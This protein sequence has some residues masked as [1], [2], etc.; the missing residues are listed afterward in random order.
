MNS[1]NHIQTLK[2]LALAVLATPFSA[3]AQDAF[4]TLAPLTVTGGEEKVYELLGAAAYL[5]AEDIRASGRTDIGGLLAKIPGVYVRDEDG[6]GNFPNISLRGADG[7]RSE[8]V[9]I[10][11]DGILT[12]PSPYSAPAAYYSP[13]GARMSGIEVLKGSSQVRYG[14]QTTGGV[15]NFLSTEIP[16]ER[17]FYS[18][19]TYGSFNTFFNHT[20]YGDTVETEAGRIGYLLEL[21]TQT[22]DGFRDI[23]FS[24]RDTG[25]GLIEP[26]LKVFWEPD[27]ALK[28]RIEM[29]AGYTNFDSNETY[30]GLTETDLAANPDRRYAATQFDAFGSEQWRTYVKWIAEPSDSLRIE[31]AVYYNQFSRD[32]DKIDQVNGNPLHQALLTPAGVGTLNGSAAGNIRL[33]NNLRDHE[34]YGWQSQMNYLFETGQL[35]HDLGF[36]V[37]FH[38]DR[39]DA[40]RQRTVYNGNGTGGFALAP[41][42][43]GAITPN[44]TNET[45]ATAVFV[46]DEIKT[47]KFT[48]RPGIRY[49][50]LD[51]DFTNPAGGQF[52]GNENLFAAGVGGSYE[53]DENSS[54]F[55]GIYRGVASPSPQAYL[56]AGTENEE[57]LSYELGYRYRKDAFNA[58]VVGFFTDF[59]QLISTDAGFGFTNTNQNAGQAEVF[60]LET[61]VEYD[62]GND[63]NLGV[64]LPLYVS[65]TWT[66][67]QF[68]G[69]NIA[70][71]GG[72]GVYDGGRSGNEIPY[73]PDW[74][75]AAG[76][77]VTG[78]K[79]GVNLDMIY[80]SSMWGTGFNGDVRPGTQ[81][82]RD[83]EIPA[84]LLFDL[85]ANYRIN[86][87][88]KLVGGI[89]N[90][91]DERE[92][93]SRIPEGPRSNAPRVFFAGVEA[94]F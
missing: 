39:Q 61:L 55:G 84:L 52:S 29:K 15:I 43:P 70:G 33:S 37:R 82:I 27:T 9:T 16:D 24:G 45:F 50:W 31:S 62:A 47:G 56:T 20:W 91:F 34:G 18:R 75:I 10:M 88:L 63:Y 8:K 92:I 69:G 59:S 28:Q 85:T 14:P 58:E 87:N 48:L 38:Y 26:M 73:I 22:S 17:S 19:T 21:H 64:G 72:Q 36:G 4:Q 83:G 71:G 53:I 23:D 94:T 12:A 51:L 81:T 30:T 49:E 40:L 2:L 90:I 32:W 42:Q 7:T 74:K 67:A 93:V 68:T 3:N 77:G 35:S 78:E 5:S 13:K 76:I 54:L 25:F 44:G 65:A 11:E 1:K 6:F 66:S 41:G 86:E 80:T 79:W 46:E 60:G 57:S 89:Q